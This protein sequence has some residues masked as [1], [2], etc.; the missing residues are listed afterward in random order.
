MLDLGNWMSIQAVVTRVHHRRGSHPDALARS[1]EDAWNI[2]LSPSAFQNVHERLKIVLHCIVDDNGRTS[3]VERKR[4]K[5]FRDCMILEIDDDD[6]NDDLELPNDDDFDDNDNSSTLVEISKI[7]FSVASC[8]D[9]DLNIQNIEANRDLSGIKW[10][11]F[12]RTAHEA[13]SIQ[14]R[15]NRDQQGFSFSYSQPYKDTREGAKTSSTHPVASDTATTSQ[16]SQSYAPLRNLVWP[17]DIFGNSSDLSQP[18]AHLLPAGQSHEEWTHIA[19]SVVGLDKD[20]LPLD[21]IKAVRGFKIDGNKTTKRAPG[22]G[23]VHFVSNKIRMANQGILFDGQNAN[24][25]L[26]PTIS[27]ESAKAWKGEA[28][29]ALF[30]VGLPKTLGNKEGPGVPQIY[31]QVGLTLS[32]AREKGVIRDASATEIE[33]A[34]KTLTHAILAVRD[35]LRNTKAETRIESFGINSEKDVAGVKRSHEVANSINYPLPEIDKEDKQR[36]PLCLVEFGDGADEGKHP[37]PDPLLLAYKA[38]AIWGMA[39]DQRLLAN[40]EPQDPSANMSEDDYLAEF[41]F[42]E[43]RSGF[44]RPQT[45]E[46]LAIGLGQPNGYQASR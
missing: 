12:W 18:I 27:L 39:T 31:Q 16:H 10:T 2:Y 5:L 42:L 26:I 37:A 11:N 35:Y 33:N 17:I 29:S 25:I 21:W 7:E 41:A 1:V 24:A 23:V 40:G 44:K 3:L 34:R 20:G 45:L 19:A 8:G 14:V 28:Y 43:A 6:T 15:K 22:S 30:A 32:D 46:D 38:A 13:D 9:I 4:G 36:K